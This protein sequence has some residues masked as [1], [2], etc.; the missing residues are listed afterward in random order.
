MKELKNHGGEMLVDTAPHVILAHCTVHLCRVS[1]Y[2]WDQS[3][4]L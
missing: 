3:M 4:V 1:L 2:G